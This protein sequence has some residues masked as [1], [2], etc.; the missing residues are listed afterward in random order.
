MS[1]SASKISNNCQ[2]YCK[3]LFNKLEIYL[4]PKLLTQVCQHSKND[5]LQTVN[6]TSRQDM[7]HQITKFTVI[8]L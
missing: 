2:K 6:V 4:I 8:L 7:K 5:E 1:P 3:K